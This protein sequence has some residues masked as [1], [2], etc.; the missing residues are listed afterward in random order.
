MEHGLSRSLLIAAQIAR[1]LYTLEVA[2][3][4]SRCSRSNHAIAASSPR[5]FVVD[6]GSVVNMTK[7]FERLLRAHEAAE[8]LA[9]SERN[10]WKLSKRGDLPRVEMGGSV[11]Y[12]P[13]DLRAWIERKKTSGAQPDADST[14]DQQ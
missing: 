5:H 13:A 10:L 2:F 9:I 12:D 11:R 6:E 1:N 4:F 8:L 3:S 7:D 14:T